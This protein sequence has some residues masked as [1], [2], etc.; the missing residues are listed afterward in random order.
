MNSWISQCAWI[1]KTKLHL[2]IIFPSVN[3]SSVSQRTRFDRNIHSYLPSSKK[4]L[5]GRG[6]LASGTTK[7]A[8]APL[9]TPR[10]NSKDK[11]KET[12]SRGKK[13]RRRGARWRDGSS[14][15]L[16]REDSLSCRL[17]VIRRTKT[18]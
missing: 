8:R 15:F 16:A 5:S 11:I 14:A 7:L 18:S 17:S 13:D 3:H 10:A 9:S 4:L 12:G 2:T 6:S 1:S